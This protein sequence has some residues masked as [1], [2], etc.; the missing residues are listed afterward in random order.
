MTCK[1][2]GALNPDINTVC[3]NC[4]AKLNENIEGVNQDSRFFQGMNGNNADGVGTNNV[5]SMNNMTANMNMPNDGMNNA[6]SINSTNNNN[7]N[8]K[9]ILVI[10]L[11]VVLLVVVAVGSFFIGKS[12]TSNDN[13][14]NQENNQSNEEENN[15]NNQDNEQAEVSDTISVTSNGITYEIPNKYEYTERSGQLVVMPADE[16]WTVYFSPMALSYTS[17]LTNFD[18]LEANYGAATGITNMTIEE[19]VVNGLN[20]VLIKGIYRGVDT[21]IVL[22][23]LNSSTTIFATV[24]DLNGTDEALNAAAEISKSAIMARNGEINAT[25]DF[26]EIDEAFNEFNK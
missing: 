21:Y 8:K 14:N 15:D 4:G 11:I 23:R 6:T 17:V 12:L 10:I 2:C 1:N 5:N 19:T 20:C 7:G 22:S 3:I 16:S 25:D 24:L 9:F 13:Q 18:T 26:P